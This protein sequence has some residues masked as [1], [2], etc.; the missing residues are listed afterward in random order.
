MFPCKLHLSQTGSSTAPVIFTWSPSGGPTID[1]MQGER[2][3]AVLI[4]R[5]LPAA[6][7]DLGNGCI[8]TPLGPLGPLGLLRQRG[9]Y[10]AVPPDIDLELN[11]LEVNR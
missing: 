3:S 9:E 10:L 5:H 7:V 8:A 4:D 1:A 6:K 11:V 2:R